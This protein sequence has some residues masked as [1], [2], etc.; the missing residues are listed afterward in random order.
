MLLS[1]AGVLLSVIVL[2]YIVVGARPGQHTRLVRG[3]KRLRNAIIVTY[4]ILLGLNLWC[5]LSPPGEFAEDVVALMTLTATG[6]WG[7]VVTK[8]RIP[9]AVRARRRK[10]LAVGAHPDD[11]ELACGGTL[12][13]LVD[14][15]HEVRGL[16]MS[17][18]EV[19][20][21]SGMRPDEAR[22]GASFL[23]LSDMCVLNFPDTKLETVNNDMVKAIETAVTE[24]GPDV[25]FTHSAHDQHQDHYA[26]HQATLRAARAHHSILCFESPSV[27][28]DFDPSVFVDIDG[29]VD[30]KVEAVLTHRNQAGKPYMTPQRVRAMAAFRGAQAKNTN[31]EA[32]EPVRLL[33][34]A[35]GDL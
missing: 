14:A 6:A 3:A 1:M 24:F 9:I 5:V 25:I 30:V 33:G 7:L 22:Q 29:Y 13:K 11:L 10:I 23:G 18:G 31:A 20:G 28:R 8:R 15:G 12:A 2:G 26:V 35:I 32:F 19:G 34:S 17:S 4:V 16:V 21:N 27:T